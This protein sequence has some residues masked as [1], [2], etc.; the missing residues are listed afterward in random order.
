MFR[1]LLLLLLSG[2]LSACTLTGKRTL[3]EPSLNADKQDL[4][5]VFQ[6]DENFASF[7]N[8]SEKLKVKEVEQNAL[9]FG[10]PSQ[11]F[12]WTVSQKISGT[13]IAFQLFRVGTQQCRK[14]R[15]TVT[16]SKINEISEATACLRSNGKWQLVR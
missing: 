2:V 6:S 12:D 1:F 7:L 10:K 3:D 9:N 16:D 13:V 8:Q 11:V 4:A 14:F 15:H 5:L